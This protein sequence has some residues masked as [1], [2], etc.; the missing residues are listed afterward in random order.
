MRNLLV[1]DSQHKSVEKNIQLQVLH[2]LTY[3]LYF[4]YVG[5]VNFQTIYIYISSH[6]IV[7][8]FYASVLVEV[9]VQF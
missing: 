3:F 1:H 6:D 7:L 8:Y 5:V 4:K 9:I 2:L